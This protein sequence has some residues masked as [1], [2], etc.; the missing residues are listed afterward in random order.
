[1]R[2]YEVIANLLSNAIKFTQ[3][4]TITISADIRSNINNNSISELIIRI[5]DTGTGIHPEIIQRLFTKFTNQVRKGN[6]TWTVYF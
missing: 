2:L 1:M 3:N 6:W 5:R 4:G